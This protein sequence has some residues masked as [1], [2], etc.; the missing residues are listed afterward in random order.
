MNQP[1]RDLPRD[2]NLY[3]TKTFNGGAPGMRPPSVAVEIR[4]L[5]ESTTLEVPQARPQE[6]GRRAAHE[7]DTLRGRNPDFLRERGG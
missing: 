3:V 5:V 1:A 6:G 4:V 2:R 7:I